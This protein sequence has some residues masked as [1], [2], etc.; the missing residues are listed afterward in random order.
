MSFDLPRRRVR[1]RFMK[2]YETSK[3][4][5]AFDV[6]YIILYL[7]SYSDSSVQWQHD[8]K[9]RRST[10]VYSSCLPLMIFVLSLRNFIRLESFDSTR[11][12]RVRIF[13]VRLLSNNYRSSIE[14]IN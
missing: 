14:H 8:I 9:I 5:F 12:Y 4:I 1:Q 10:K 2:F 13:T 3:N 11:V 6:Y 7:T